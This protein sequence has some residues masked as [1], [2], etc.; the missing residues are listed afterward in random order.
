VEQVQRGEVPEYFN[1]KNTGTRILDIVLRTYAEGEDRKAFAEKALGLLKEAY[2][3]AERIWGGA[4]PDLVLQTRDAVFRAIERFG[5]GASLE[6]VY[7]S[8]EEA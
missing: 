4:L 3:D 7:G 5:E 2:G 6:E 8:L 1:V